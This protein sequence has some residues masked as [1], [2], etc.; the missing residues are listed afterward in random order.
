[1][2]ADS[3]VELG[4]PG[5]CHM[6]VTDPGLQSIECY[7]VDFANKKSLSSWHSARFPP[8]PPCPRPQSD[9]ERLHSVSRGSTSQIAA[10]YTLP[11]FHFCPYSASIL[12]TECVF[13]LQHSP[14]AMQVDGRWDQ[15]C[16]GTFCRVD[17][18]FIRCAGLRWKKIS[19]FMGLLCRFELISELSCVRV[20]L[21][22][23]S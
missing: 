11:P 6:T 10:L 21:S 23:S 3:S 8:P 7:A 1:M 22:L 2:K 13:V 9:F 20:C 4:M 17:E 18:V 14:S 19:K 5:V 15:L 12:L 16:K